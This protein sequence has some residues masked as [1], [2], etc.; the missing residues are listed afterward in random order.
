MP[1]STGVFANFSREFANFSREFVL[2]ALLQKL[3]GDLCFDFSQGNLEN[4]VGKL[5]GIFRGFFL[6]HRTKAQNFR[7][8]FRSIFRK[9]IR[10][11]KNI[12]HAKF[13]LQTCHLKNLPVLSENST[14]LSKHSPNLSRF[15]PG[16]DQLYPG[17]RK[18]AIYNSKANDR[19]H[20][21]MF[22]KTRA[23]C[24]DSIADFFRVCSLIIFLSGGVFLA[25]LPCQK[26]PF[27]SVFFLAFPNISGV[28]QE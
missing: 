21:A 23:F 8:K 20:Q 13:T 15:H 28:R 19:T 9:K 16:F 4:L 24:S 1:L 12:F 3:V 25:F 18:E 7:G 2:P 27:S 14:N 22:F 5:E 17:N 6:T 11:S 10:G 26:F